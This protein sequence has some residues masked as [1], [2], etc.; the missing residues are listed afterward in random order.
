MSPSS[1]GWLLALAGWTTLA[2]RPSLA[3]HDHHHHESPPAAEAPAPAIP[4]EAVT[5]AELEARAVEARPLLAAAAARLEAARSEARQAG[6]LANPALG[7]KAEELPL[8]S[9]PSRGKVGLVWSQQLPLAGQL[10]RS[11]S[12]L[13]A[14]A[15]TSEGRLILA[16]AGVQAEVRRAFYRAVSGQRALVQAQQVLALAREAVEVTAQLFNTGAA[17]RPDQLAIEVDAERAELAVAEA[18]QHLAARR[19]E[20]ATAVGD[21]ALAARPLADTFED[22]APDPIEESWRSG[23]LAAAPELELERRAVVA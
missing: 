12:W 13:E 7:L 1:R 22:L 23:A 9:G 3:Q 4:D 11:R 20:L 10:S 18:E 17:D 14:E 8:E 21:T 2:G 5:L 19:A 16:R 6:R 15:G